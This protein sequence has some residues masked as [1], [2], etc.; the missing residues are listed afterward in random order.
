[1]KTVEIIPGIELTPAELEV[2]NATRRDKFKPNVDWDHI[3]ET[4]FEPWLF[5]LV[6]EDREIKAFGSLQDIDLIIDKLTLPIL[7]IKGVASLEEGKGYG[8]SLIEAM[9]K[10]AKE[11]EEILVG[12]C[13]PKN[14]GFYIKSGLKVKENGNLNFVHKKED[15]S[16]H[17]DDGD[18]IY[19]SEF[20][21]EITKAI[22]EGKRI[23]HLIPH[24]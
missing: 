14:R 19:Y 9:V 5:F 7:G 15:G 21:N 23:Y 22:E 1:M 10:Y 8:K 17:T 11:N 3:K 18:V 6:K 20:K 16:E 4:V 12:F 24:W 13:D 2:I